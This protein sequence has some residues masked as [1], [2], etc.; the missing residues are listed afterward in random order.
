V[1]YIEEA[2]L[3]AAWLMFARLAGW[4]LL[5]PLLRRMGQPWP[6]RLILAGGLT[7][8]F[9]PGVGVPPAAP[10]GLAHLVIEFALGGLLGFMAQLL[11][12]VA[13]LALAW[14]GLSSR[15]G[16]S[17]GSVAGL[18]AETPFSAWVPWLAMLAFVG[19]DGHLYLVQALGQSLHSLPQVW[20]Q[21]ELLR[22]WVGWGSALFSLS[23]QL[24]GPWLLWMVLV[25]FTLGFV[26]R[27]SPGADIWSQ[28]LAVSGL[29]LLL[30]V[31][32]LLPGVLRAME[33]VFSRPLPVFF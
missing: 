23:L 32:W 24:A 2:W 9:L 10:I 15:Y 22:D 18:P 26:A 16:L 31:S 27:L 30:A 13:E 20:P 8:A 6:M 29:A 1:F 5:D 7:A 4:A 3:A 11:F 19:A 28:G 12:A 33:G 25:Q 17:A 21:G 14:L